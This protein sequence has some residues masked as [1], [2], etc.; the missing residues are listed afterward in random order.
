M[1]DRSEELKQEI[2]VLRS[3]LDRQTEQMRAAVEQLQRLEKTVVP[4][5]SNRPIHVCRKHP[6]NF[7]LFFVLK[8]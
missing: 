3:Q 8:F 5:S 2:A 4:Q 7:P 1:G 6:I